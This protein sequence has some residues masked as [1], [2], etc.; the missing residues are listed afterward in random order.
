MV[1]DALLQSPSFFG[2]HVN[3][4]CTSRLLDVYWTC[5]GATF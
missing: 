4:T 3:V 2:Q 5:T 1:S